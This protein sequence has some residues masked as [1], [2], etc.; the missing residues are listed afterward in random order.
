[1]MVVV[2]GPEG[3]DYGVAEAPLAFPGPG[4]FSFSSPEALVAGIDEM[5]GPMVALRNE[6]G[7]LAAEMFV[8]AAKKNSIRAARA[9]R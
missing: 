1:M 8:A 7:G 6:A 2:S 4:S 3:V 5:E 9:A